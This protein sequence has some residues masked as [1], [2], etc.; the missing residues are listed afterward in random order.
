[1][2]A[3]TCS[4]GREDWLRARNMSVNEVSVCPTGAV[5]PSQQQHTFVREVVS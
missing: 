2:T 1:M 4:G 3:N 5:Y